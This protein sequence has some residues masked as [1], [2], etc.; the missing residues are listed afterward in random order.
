MG[1]IRFRLTLWYAAVVLIAGVVL[2]ALVYILVGRAFPERDPE[3]LGRVQ[4]R[5]ALQA[6]RADLQALGFD[7]VPGTLRPSPGGG[8]RAGVLLIDL[9]EEAR[10]EARDQAF[11]ALVVQSSVALGVLMLGSLGAGWFISGRMLRP[12]SDITATVQRITADRLHER[13]ALVGPR[14]ELKELGDQF[15]AMLDRLDHAFRAQREFVANASHELR[16]PLAVMRTEL[17]VTYDDPD[18]S[19]EDLRAGAVV[20]R[21]AI[22]RAE[23]LIAALLTL[24]R[25]DAPRVAAD[26]VDLADVARAALG[27]GSA[28]QGLELR[29]TLAPALV[30]GDRVLLERMVGNLIANALAYNAE[31]GW[32]EIETSTEGG[33]AVLRVANAGDVIDPASV[34]W[35]FERFRR[36]DDSRSRE[37]GGYGVGLAIVRAVARH[38]G[39]EASARALEAGGLEVT[40]R[41]P[42]LPRA[43]T[44]ESL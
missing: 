41:I 13:V 22:A 8:D 9:V 17:D 12:V 39:G 5:P 34:E 42:A 3:F 36:R 28:D 21:R 33:T 37:S 27:A 6:R 4:D 44:R 24:E 32:I 14:D 15:D 30:S 31:R 2:L 10:A 7:F 20:M 35:L 18:A 43:A 38:H 29:S 11:R 1:T 23:A 40:V 26:P 25:A 19:I 16:T